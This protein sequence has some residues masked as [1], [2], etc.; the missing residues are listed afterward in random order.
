MPQAPVA[1]PF[2][3]GDFGDEARLKPYRAP[4]LRSRHHD[5]GRGLALER[6]EALGEFAEIGFAE[7]GA[8]F[9]GIVKR[10]VLEGAEQKRGKRAPLD[11][12]A[13]IAADHEFGARPTFDLEPG[14]AAAGA[15]GRVRPFRH[16]AF[17]PQ[18]ARAR[19]EGAPRSLHMIGIDKA[20][21]DGFAREQLGEAGLALQERRPAP[22]LAVE[23]EQI[24]QEIADRRVR[25]VDM[26][27]Q[28]FE[29]RDAR[30]QHE[31]HFAVDQR[32]AAGEFG[33]RPGHGREPHGPVEPAAAEQRDLGAHLPPDDTVAVEFHL[34]QPAFAVRHLVIEGGELRRDECRR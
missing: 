9:A 8:H 5:E 33:E 28:R 2:G 20:W 7:S 32:V 30:R 29:V 19:Q 12:G 26:L 13:A 11:R 34:M 14:L 27:L 31:G 21:R 10:T 23:L 18:G 16:D 15:I 24:E 6:L 25:A 22:I 1:R 3:I 17:E 4:P